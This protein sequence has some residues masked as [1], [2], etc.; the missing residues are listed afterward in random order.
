MSEKF[1]PFVIALFLI[2]IKTWTKKGDKEKL[3]RRVVYMK[4]YFFLSLS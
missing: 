3:T 2:F 1:K 4:R